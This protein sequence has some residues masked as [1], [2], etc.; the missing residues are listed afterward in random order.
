M[1]PEDLVSKLYP[2]I[3]ACTCDK[4][5]RKALKLIRKA[6]AEEREACA[7]V[8][9]SFDEAMVPSSFAIAAAIRARKP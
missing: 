2:A 1:T 5:K 3:D 6:I 8:A 9:A 4:C 7:L